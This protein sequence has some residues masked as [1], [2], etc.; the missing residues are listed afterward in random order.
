MRPSRG[1]GCLALALTLLAAPFASAQPAL[2]TVARSGRPAPGLPAGV[3]FD[4]FHAAVIDGEGNVAFGA[5]ARTRD[6]TGSYVDAVWLAR[7]RGRTRLVLREDAKLRGFPGL[8]LDE[9]RS[10]P[11]ILTPD[12]KPDT[13]WASTGYRLFDLGGPN[14]FF[15][16]AALSPDGKRVALVGIEGAATVAADAGTV[17]DDDDGALMLLSLE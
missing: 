4:E 15:W 11:S 16:G 6:S 9:P 1:F 2:R 5:S 7:P 10:N 13:T 3:T 17:G 12:G 14:D 8:L